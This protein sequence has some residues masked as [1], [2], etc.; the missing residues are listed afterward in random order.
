MHY[1]TSACA[2]GRCD[3]CDEDKRDA[4]NA[5]DGSEPPACT[6]PGCG[7]VPAFACPTAQNYDRRD[8]S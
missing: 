2:A 3:Q 8:N 7:C 6:Y 4:I 1:K 5:W